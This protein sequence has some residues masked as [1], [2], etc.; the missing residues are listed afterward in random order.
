MLKLIT[1]IGRKILIAIVYLKKKRKEPCAHYCC[2]ARHKCK[3]ESNA[4]GESELIN[5]V[6]TI[7]FRL[8]MNIRIIGSFKKH[9]A[10]LQT[11]KSS[12]L[13]PVISINH[14]FSTIGYKSKRFWKSCNKNI[15]STNLLSINLNIWAQTIFNI[16]LI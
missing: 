4:T 8:A 5:H 16:F 15:N 12:S 1:W 3:D 9:D 14:F 7:H 10:H 13:H 11:I 6:C 2:K